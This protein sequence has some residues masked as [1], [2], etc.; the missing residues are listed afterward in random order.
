M[1]SRHGSILPGGRATSGRGVRATG[2]AQSGLGARRRG[3]AVHRGISLFS[4]GGRS[5]AYSSDVGLGVG[6]V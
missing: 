4:Y 5:Y 6:L 2:E 3:D 1:G